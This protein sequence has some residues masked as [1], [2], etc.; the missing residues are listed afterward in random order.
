VEASGA[1]DGESIRKLSTSVHEGK[2]RIEKLFTALE[3]LTNEHD[4]RAKE[5]EKK[6]AEVQ[7]G[8]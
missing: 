8:A 1:G 6:P 7:Q 5:F 2:E 4:A 3:A